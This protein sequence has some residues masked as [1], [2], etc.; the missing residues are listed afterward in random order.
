MLSGR[1]NARR[2]SKTSI[3]SA[4]ALTPLNVGAGQDRG[5]MYPRKGGTG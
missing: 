1:V 5:G 2:L 4:D 3:D